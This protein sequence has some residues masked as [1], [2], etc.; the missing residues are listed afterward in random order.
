M[1][2]GV[3]PG[4]KMSKK[5]LLMFPV[6]SGLSI[7]FIA[8]FYFRF[9]NFVNTVFEIKG[10][11]GIWICLLYSFDFFFLKFVLSFYTFWLINHCTF[12]SLPCLVLQVLFW[13]VLHVY[14][15]I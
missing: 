12:Y 1:K 14:S 7:R 3:R 10:N 4:S 8:Q 11:S 6:K 9:L 15:G 2:T 5:C 13:D